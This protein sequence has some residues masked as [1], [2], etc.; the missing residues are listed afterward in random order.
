MRMDRQ[1]WSNIQQVLMVSGKKMIESQ[2]ISRAVHKSRFERPICHLDAA[3]YHLLCIWFH[4]LSCLTFDL[5][6]VTK[7]VIAIQ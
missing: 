3:V 4:T 1:L 6:Y 5:L 2:N 7:L